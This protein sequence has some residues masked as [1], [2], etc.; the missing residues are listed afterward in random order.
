MDASDWYDYTVNQGGTFLIVLLFSSAAFSGFI[1]SSAREEDLKGVIAIA[2]IVLL[3]I[4]ECIKKILKKIMK[5]LDLA[6]EI[7]LF[8]SRRLLKKDE[9]DS[10]ERW[11]FAYVNLFNDPY[12]VEKT[13]WR[14]EYRKLGVFRG[15]M[16]IGRG[17][18][19]LP[20]IAPS[21]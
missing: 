16:L 4:G 9:S 2:F 6:K 14:S 3:V 20:I 18:F 10:I 5:N 12:E 8:E 19:G 13:H 1:F 7:N 17:L 15:I 21:I 11:G